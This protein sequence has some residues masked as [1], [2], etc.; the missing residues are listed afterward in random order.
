MAASVVGQGCKWDARRAR[1][2]SPPAAPAPPAGSSWS[3]SESP[4]GGEEG[5]ACPW[6]RSTRPVGAL[7]ALSLAWA[8]DSVMSR[9]ASVTKL[10]HD[11]S[12][13]RVQLEQMS[14]VF[15]AWVAKGGT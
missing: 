10:R 14:L 11:P 1:L 4:A 13:K 12:K 9:V 8:L 6:P 15:W 2:G 7:A 3:E 5:L